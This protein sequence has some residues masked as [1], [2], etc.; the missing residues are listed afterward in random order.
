MARAARSAPI[1]TRLAPSESSALPHIVRVTRRR[2]AHRPVD[3]RL[4]GEPGEPT[5]LSHERDRS[6]QYSRRRC[7]EH[8]SQHGGQLLQRTTLQAARQLRGLLGELWRQ[9]SNLSSRRGVA[10]WRSFVPEDGH[11]RLPLKKTARRQLAGFCLCPG[12][13]LESPAPE[14]PALSCHPRL[15]ASDTLSDQRLEV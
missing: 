5:G 12:A 2:R 10:F 14:C 15:Q 3:G 8:R 13:P 6:S 9:G 7:S 1:T 11:V 4:R